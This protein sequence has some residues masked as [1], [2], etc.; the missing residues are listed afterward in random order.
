MVV[1]N[2]LNKPLLHEYDARSAVAAAA[3]YVYR[4]H[5]GEPHA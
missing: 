1:T 5:L 2:A 3:P 4:V